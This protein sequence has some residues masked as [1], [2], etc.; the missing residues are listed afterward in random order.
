[1][2]IFS[3]GA[4]GISGLSF[5]EFVL[6]D[7]SKGKAEDGDYFRAGLDEDDFVNEPGVAR[8]ICTPQA[9]TSGRCGR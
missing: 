3:V 8:S 7:V 1:M 6:G 4:V 2:W 5:L 9:A